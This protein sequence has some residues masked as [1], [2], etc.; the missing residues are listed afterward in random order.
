MVIQF[1]TLRRSLMK[2]FKRCA[3]LAAVLGVLVVGLKS[4]RYVDDSGVSDMGD[5]NIV[6]GT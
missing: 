3:L 5:E 6:W 2:N 1:A 4:T